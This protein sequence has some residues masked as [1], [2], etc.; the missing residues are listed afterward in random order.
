MQGNG[1]P[2]MKK[3]PTLVS[4]F[5]TRILVPEAGLEPARLAAADFESAT[6]TNS[7]T[8]ATLDQHYT[9]W[10]DRAALW[11]ICPDTATVSPGAG[12]AY[13]GSLYLN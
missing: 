1:R 4:A 5:L 7:I 8:R 3:A 6:S 13:A 12:L 10:L 2:E 9:A 11:P